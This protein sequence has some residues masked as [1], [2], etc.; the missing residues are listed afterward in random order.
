MAD[1]FPVDHDSGLLPEA[2]CSLYPDPVM[3]RLFQTEKN[4]VF[5]RND[6]ILQSLCAKN[7]SCPL[8]PA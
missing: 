1:H 2:E 4:L 6:L 5:S 8:H 3:Q 7:V